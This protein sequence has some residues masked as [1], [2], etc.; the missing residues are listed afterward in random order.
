MGIVYQK[1]GARFVDTVSVEEAEGL[2]AW[3]QANR[4]GKL[5]LSACTH[6]HAANL[7]V[8]MAD[9][10]QISK[11]PQDETLKM[12]LEAALDRN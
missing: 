12:W 5:D 4:S 6:L 8:M 11:W 3:L 10:V 2:L 1:R 7:Q 9:W